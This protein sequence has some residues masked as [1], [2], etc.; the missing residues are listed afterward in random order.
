MKPEVWKKGLGDLLLGFPDRDLTPEQQKARGEVYRRHL[1]EL[2]EDAWLF[3]VDQALDTL[4]WFPTIAELKDL[5]YGWFDTPPG[6]IEMER[7]RME[8]YRRIK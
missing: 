7:V 4:T 3:A 2:H 5:A 1:D 8:K 6:R